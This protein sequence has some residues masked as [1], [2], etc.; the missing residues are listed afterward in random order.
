MIFFSRRREKKEKK[1]S[2]TKQGNPQLSFSLL[3]SR[4]C[5]SSSRPARPRSCRVRTEGVSLE[6]VSATAD[7]ERRAKA[8]IVGSSRAFVLVALA[9]ASTSSLEQK[10]K[11]KSLLLVLQVVLF[12]PEADHHGRLPHA[13]GPA[14]AAPVAGKTAAAAGAGAA[15]GWGRG[16]R[17][18]KE[19]ASE[20]V[21]FASLLLY[22]APLYLLLFLFVVV[23]VDW[24]D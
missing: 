12:L 7:V 16:F 14:G 22:T 2:R 4:S 19:Q 18:V 17:K 21:P 3:L 1:H 24:Y 11:K 9:S 10:K 6:T 8:C 13:R 23:I 5:A 15:G 20:S